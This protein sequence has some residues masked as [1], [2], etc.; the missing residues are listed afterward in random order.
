MIP[1]KMFQA[2]TDAAEAL[3]RAFDS[4]N[5]E[6]YIQADAEYMRLTD[7][8]L[9]REWTHEQRKEWSRLMTR[10]CE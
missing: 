2:A 10:L 9:W 7:E 6:R 3:R 8:M 5:V 4:G 1:E